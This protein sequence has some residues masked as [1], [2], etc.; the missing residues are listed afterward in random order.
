MPTIWLCGGF[1]WLQVAPNVEN[2]GIPDKIKPRA[3]TAVETL[4]KT[5]SQV[6]LLSSEDV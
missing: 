4:A 3:A 6:L 5:R 2:S 1:G